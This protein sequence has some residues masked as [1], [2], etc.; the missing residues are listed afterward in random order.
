MKELTESERALKKNP[1]IKSN[2]IATIIRY[3]VAL[4]KPLH[5]PETTTI[6]CHNCHI[7]PHIAQTYFP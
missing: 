5:Y 4:Q 2:T 1:L 7:V 6:L 3:D